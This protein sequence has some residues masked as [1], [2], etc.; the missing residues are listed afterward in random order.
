MNQKQ[1]KDYE[2]FISNL[3]NFLAN[4]TMKYKFLVISNEKVCNSFDSFEKA[5]EYAL[6]NCP[7]DDFIIQQAIDESKNINYIHL[8]C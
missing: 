2:F 4:E 7:A 3:K 1:E 5:L 8:G 6:N